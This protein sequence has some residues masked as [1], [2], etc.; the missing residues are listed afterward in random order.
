MALRLTEEQYDELLSKRLVKIAKAAMASLPALEVTPRPRAKSRDLEHQ[1]AVALI[2]WRDAHV[3]KYPELDELYA[4]P[5]G[6]KRSKRT[7]GRLK[8]EGVKSGVSDYHLP[9][10]RGGFIGCYIE[11]KAAGGTASKKQREWIEKMRARGHWAGV[12]VGWEAARDVLVEYL[13]MGP[14]KLDYYG[15]II[16]GRHVEAHNEDHKRTR[17]GAKAAARGIE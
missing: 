15:P 3:G 4:I 12:C 16:P 7:R 17:A 5:N 1:E 14:T 2:E 10:A 6:G 11:L 9:V 13:S 8:A